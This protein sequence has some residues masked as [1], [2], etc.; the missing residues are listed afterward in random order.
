M[1]QRRLNEIR[2]RMPDKM[3]LLTS[4]KEKTTRLSD[5]DESRTETTGKESMSPNLI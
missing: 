4:H 3:S 5:R 2:L 1:M